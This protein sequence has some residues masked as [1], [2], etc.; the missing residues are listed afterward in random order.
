MPGPPPAFNPDDLL[1]DWGEADSDAIEDSDRECGSFNL[2]EYPVTAADYDRFATSEPSLSHAFCHPAEP[3]GKIHMRNTVLDH[4]IG[5]DHPVT[6]VDW[7]DAYS[8]AVWQGKRL[9]TEVEWQRAAQGDQA[10]AYPWGDVFDAWRAHCL[11]PPRE[12]GADAVRAWRSALL[13]LVDGSNLQTTRPVGATCSASQYGICDLSGNAWEWTATAFWGGLVTPVDMGRDAIEIVYD[14][15]S[16]AVLKGG[17]WTSL[18]EQV[19]GAF[20]GRDLILDRHFEIGF[21]CA[22]DCPTS[23]Y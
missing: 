9:P 2:D 20:R 10:W 11:A 14:P 12:R 5:P 13:A 4:R 19:S 1:F 7:F 16:Y 3:A 8:Y 23:A 22:C 6:G 18:P 21:R 17:A 15:R